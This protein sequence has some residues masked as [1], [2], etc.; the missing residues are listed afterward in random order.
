[1]IKVV[2]LFRRR[3]GM[4]VAAFQE[5]RRTACVEVGPIRG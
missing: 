4:G 5:H 3:P 2:N 1:M